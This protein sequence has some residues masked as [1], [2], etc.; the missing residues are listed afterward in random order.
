ML[1]PT[2]W[3]VQTKLHPPRLVRLLALSLGQTRSS[4]ERT[5]L[6]ARLSASE[7]Q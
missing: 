2:I 4:A 5:A 3:L 7:R 1:E 6:I